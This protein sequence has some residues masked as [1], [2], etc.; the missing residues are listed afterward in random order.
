LTYLSTSISVAALTLTALIACA[1]KASEPAANVEVQQPAENSI[2]YPSARMGDTVDTFFG[3]EVADPYRWMED[4]DSEETRAWIEAENAITR[5]WLGD[6]ESRDAIR[7]RLQEVWNYPK[8]SSP[9]LMGGN[10]FVSANDG[11][12]EHSVLYVGDTLDG[13]YLPLI[14]PNTF[15]ED[16]TVSLAGYYPSE[17]GQYVAYG[18]SDGGSD[19]KH[20][21]VVNVATGEVLEDRVEWVKFSGA[22]WNH[23]STGFY[24]SRFPEPSNL[25]EGVNEHNQIYFHTVGTPQSEDTLIWE[26]LANPEF[27]YSAG[28]TEDGSTLVLYG[29]NSTDDINKLWFRPEAIT[30]HRLYPEY[31]DLEADWQPLF[32]ENDA[33]YVFLAKIDETVWMRTNRDAPNSRVVSFDLSE[34]EA[35]TEVVPERPEPIVNV[36]VVGGRVLVKYLVDASSKVEVFELDGTVVGEVPLPGIGSVWGFGGHIDNP[37]TFFVFGSYTSA[38]DIYRFDTSTMEVTL[39]KESEATFDASPYVTEQVFYASA[40][41]TQIPMFI[42][43]R[44]DIELDGDNPTLLYGYGGFSIPLTP[45]FS[46]RIAVWLDMGGVYAVANLRGGGEYGEEW[47]EAGTQLNKQN[48][49][50]DFIAAAEW[51]ISENWTNPDRLG[52]TGRSN[53]GLLVGATLLQR[54]ELFGAAIPGVGVMDML[55]Y[56]L[57]T[58]GRFWAGDYGTVDDEEQFHALHAYSPVHNCESGVEYPATLVVTADHDDRVVPAHSFK[59]AAALQAAQGGDAPVMIR[60][61]TRAGH[62]RGMPTSMKIEQSADEF[63]F[64]ARALG[65]EFTFDE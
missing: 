16:G 31:P 27:N 55:R 61:E 4:P 49:F 48:V 32:V 15:S 6:V 65:M 14:D 20:F 60:I 8:S 23:E 3:V 19:W 41:G 22:S 29:S 43:H 18:V 64:F 42:T 59:F 51:L 63:A 36:S 54:P 17:D 11:L 10:Y 12:Q 53:G 57:F 50:D 62:G 45:S 56:H 26:D 52:I 46:P 37:E 1:P 58:I 40:D 47:H 13:E 44:A 5:E 7:Q 24:Y 28:V 30:H 9:Y 25:L 34:P 33:S 38:S 39:Y 2:T 35:W 21:R